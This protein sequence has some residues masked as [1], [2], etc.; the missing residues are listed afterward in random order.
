MR[1]QVGD[2]AVIGG[3]AR[4]RRDL[5]RLEQPTRRAT[6][7]VAR[8]ARRRAP[9]RT[10]KLAGHMTTRTVGGVGQIGNAVR[11]APYQEYGTRVMRAQPYL[12]PTL[13]GTP[14]T[15]FYE[16]HADRALRQI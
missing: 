5:G 1:V 13:Y 2:K 6:E 8:D 16:D 15:S 11:Y 12:R 4:A 10:G 3:L 9:K 14:I 7:A